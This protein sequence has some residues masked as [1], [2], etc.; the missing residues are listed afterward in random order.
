MKI[1]KCLECDYSHLITLRN[2]NG[3]SQKCFLE[4]KITGEQLEINECPFEE[5]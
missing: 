5:V 4:C 1:K 2:T 3:D